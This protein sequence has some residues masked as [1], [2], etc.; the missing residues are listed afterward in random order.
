VPHITFFALLPA[1]FEVVTCILILSKGKFVKVGLA[2]SVL[3]NLFL[4]QLGLGWPG[5]FPCARC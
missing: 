5:I 2:G 1:A 4:V 3:F